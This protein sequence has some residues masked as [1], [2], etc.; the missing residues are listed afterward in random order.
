[1]AT[2]SGVAKRY[3][4]ALLDV[5]ER[6]DAVDA[7]LNDLKL[8]ETVFDQTPYFKPMITQPLI[9]AE[10]KR[11][12]LSDA[13]GDRTT[14]T[15]LN[16]LYLLV[17]K[18]RTD[19][20]PD[21]IRHYRAMIDEKKGRVVAQVQTAVPLDKKQVDALREALA[22][23]TGKSIAIEAE[24]DPAMIAGV[25]VRLGDTLIDGSVS[26]RLQRVKKR[27]LGLD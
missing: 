9:S 25:R 26:G 3:A 17:R 16:F 12:V 27:L 21:I 24:I 8:V 15:T 22:A 6:D 4:A 18:R 5:G 11:N 7:I 10:R 14:A 1:M 13:F 23:R 19:Q 2:D 20:L